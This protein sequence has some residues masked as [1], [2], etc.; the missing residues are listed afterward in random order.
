MRGADRKLDVQALGPGDVVITSYDLLVRDQARLS[1]RWATL[2]LDE[3]HA[4]KN[5]QTQRAR[6]AA[7]LEADFRLALTGTPVEN[8]L[9][10]LWS[11]MSVVLPP[12]LGPWEHFRDRYVKPIEMS[13]DA[14]VRRA[15]AGLVRPFLLRRTKSE[16]AR[17]LPPRSEVRI[18]VE[19]SP[20]ERKRYDAVRKASL[21][22][23]TGLDPHTPPEQRRFL[24]LAALTRL[25]QLASHPQ[26]VDPGAPAESAKLTALLEH[27]ETLLGEGRRALIFSQFTS[28]LD[29]VEAA[30]VEGGR[31]LLRLD[32][33]TPEKA[34]RDIV[35]RFQ[36]GEAELLLL[37]L[38]AGGV[39]LN[40]T[41]ATDVILLDPWWNP[42]V[43]DQAA[44]RAHR[45]GQTS[46]VTIWRLVA[47]ETVEEQ[48]LALHQSKRDLVAGVLEG[49]GESGA[50]TVEELMTLV[51]AG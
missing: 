26:L 9:S 40:L 10:E 41:A 25:R 31:R 22:A 44:D 30:L 2:V 47:R 24:I 19:L 46:A 16:V 18:D 34:R 1:R 6:A 38:K 17:D 37:S 7:E 11:L 45:I 5:A 43:E 8:R 49:T 4:I 33:S 39:G 20:A 13:R 27:C 35:T 36:A 12:L 50:L 29:L 48:M 3:A 51:S 21:A 32:G 15:L 42:A 14:E 23:L 28:H